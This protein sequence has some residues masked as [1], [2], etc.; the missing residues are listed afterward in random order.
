M[1]EVVADG[2]WYLTLAEEVSSSSGEEGGEGTA[3]LRWRA[4]SELA[5]R[6]DTAAQSPALSSMVIVTEELSHQE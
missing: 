1:L 3:F 6:T 5:G 4:T 2:D